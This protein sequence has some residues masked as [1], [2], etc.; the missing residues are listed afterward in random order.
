MIFGQRTATVFQAWPCSSVGSGNESCSSYRIWVARPATKRH[1][2]A[3]EY[4]GLPV[5]LLPLAGSYR[6]GVRSGAMRI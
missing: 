4:H 3:S 2:E 5:R 1:N 6:Y